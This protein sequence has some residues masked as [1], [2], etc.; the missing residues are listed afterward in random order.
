MINFTRTDLT[1]EEKITEAGAYAAKILGAYYD[2]AKKMVN[3]RIEW[4]ERYIDSLRFYTVKKNGEANTFALD[5]INEL[6]NLKNIDDITFE[7]NRCTELTDIEVGILV[8]ITEND[9][10]KNL[11]LISWFDLDS[12]KTAYELRNNLEAT[13]L[14]KKIKF[15]EAKYA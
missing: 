4:D 1:V 11:Q 9:G 12:E 10:H 5:Q 7:G 3:M 13:R 8:D 2:E 6:L 14:A 15:L